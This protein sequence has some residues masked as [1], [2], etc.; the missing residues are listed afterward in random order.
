MTEKNKSQIKSKVIIKK[1]FIR[2]ID[3][4]NQTASEDESLRPVMTS[5]FG[6][7]SPVNMNNPVTEMKDANLEHA[8]RSFKNYIKVSKTKCQK[9][10]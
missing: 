4:F 10:S 9:I 3:Q 1:R 6:Q 8:K 7:N 2:P 5:K